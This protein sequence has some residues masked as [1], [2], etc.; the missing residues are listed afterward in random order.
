MTALDFYSAAG[1]KRQTKDIPDFYSAIPEGELDETPD[2]YS[3]AKPDMLTNKLMPQSY[4]QEVEDFTELY[5]PPEM[6][7]GELKASPFEE[8][9]AYA[10]EANRLRELQQS[11][12][13]TKGALSGLTLGLT[14]N[15]PGL[16]PQENDLLVGLG[17]MAGSYLPISVMY[18]AIGTPLVKFASK[19]PKAKAGLMALARLTGFG[20]T[21][22]AYEAAKD[23]A[24]G[25]VP[26]PKELAKT[27][28][29][30]AAIDAI[31]QAMG[32]G[33]AFNQS[34]KKIAQAE[35]VTSKEV[36][37]KL[38]HSTKNFVKSRF[39][40]T[41]KPS[42]ILPADV[43]V[44]LEKAK[45]A[46]QAVTPVPETKPPEKPIEAKPV[47]PIKPKHPET[48][49]PSEWNYTREDFPTLE[50]AESYLDHLEKSRAKV[51]EGTAPATSL[52]RDI[53][54]LKEIVA[55]FEAEKPFPKRY[56][57]KGQEIYRGY[58]REK[59][60]TAY[61]ALSTGEP[62]LGPGKYY[63]FNESQAKEFGPNI[64]KKKL[65]LENP[66]IIRNDDQW[67]TF[68]KK[69]GLE[70]PNL[71]ALSAEETKE[72]LKL[73]HKALQDGGY[74]GVI[75]HF[76]ETKMGEN[77]NHEPIQLLQKIFDIAQVY[78][79]PKAE[80]AE[81]PKVFIAPPLEEALPK[82]RQVP[83][84]KTKPLKT[85]MGKEQAVARSKIIDTFRKAFTDP[86]RL[87]KFRQKA[88]GIHKMWPKVTRL[89]KAND[90]ETA[91]HEIGHNL[92]TT[93]Y[94]GNAK[95]PQEQN[96]NVNRALNPYLDELKPLAHYEPWAK[97]GFAE[98]T[99]LFVSNPDVAKELAPKFYD[100]FENDLR[101]EYPEMLNAL[102]DAREYYRRY[103][104]GTPQ[105]RIRA[106]TSYANDK[107]KLA[108]LID[109]VKKYL[110]PDNL[111]TQFLD[112]VYPAKRLVAEAFGIP[113]SE[114]ENLK[115][116]ENLYR[117][118][119]V[120]KGAVG[121]GDV[122]VLHETFDPLTLDK[123][124]GSL[125]DILKQLPDEESYRT[126]NDYLIARRSIEKASQGVGHR[127]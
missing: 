33:I 112:D 29:E 85:V 109:S 118:L 101:A 108:N 12:G 104:H 88:L 16:K 59:K 13:F 7:S 30:W 81:E 121:K 105:S 28:V 103:L 83:P 82:K 102:L 70:F 43:E 2:F 90:V 52:E 14:E 77:K 119:R 21:G 117:S 106:Q 62:L 99:R 53:A 54:N 19:S 3:L 75:I 100:K 114:V 115:D 92:H 46:E 18:K 61:S 6:T 64:E 97:E 72:N 78:E 17:E 123:I 116:E 120:L 1:A 48:I 98:F 15:V 57:E 9:K 22:M 66:L 11:R 39:Q 44:L 65:E 20:A 37:G 42:E 40:R 113:T 63:A 124:N 32:L 23:I 76:P 68:T 51:K 4:P 84:A 8:R 91:A 41:V 122:F 38:W 111:K 74:D 126:F 93:L 45:Q 69:A 94:S 26:T 31:L 60:E 49:Q 110:D 79:L 107:G 86:I 10:E 50:E 56:Q 55:G 127:C 58:G 89:L 87:G 27:G 36:L 95:T 35:G 96:V 47:E 71:L 80:L 125:R 34:I 73:I 67:R 24:K 25:E 5:A